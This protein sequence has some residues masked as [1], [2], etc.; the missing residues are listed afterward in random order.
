MGIP[1]RSTTCFNA[2]E[3][4][5]AAC[6]SAAGDREAKR[7]LNVST[8]CVAMVRPRAAMP[9][10]SVKVRSAGLGPPGSASA[11]AVTWLDQGLSYP[12]QGSVVLS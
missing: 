3:K 7:P 5:D 2:L 8:A 12:A 10:S 9:D 6:V 4:D 11:I 1:I